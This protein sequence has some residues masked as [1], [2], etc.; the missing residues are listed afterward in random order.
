MD[1]DLAT[2]LTL[3]L[4]THQL[5]HCDH[6]IQVYY[7]VLLSHTNTHTHTHSHSHSHTLNIHI[8]PHPQPHPTI[9]KFSHLA[10]AFIQSDLQCIHILHLRHTAHQEQLGVQCLAQGHFD[11]ESNYIYI[12]H[13]NMHLCMKVFTGFLYK[14]DSH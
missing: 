13:G 5:E 2:L 6:Q 4:T 7:R 1:K 3:L 11:R 12:N 8:H 14:M 9:F 10:D